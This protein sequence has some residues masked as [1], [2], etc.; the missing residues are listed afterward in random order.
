MSAAEW[1]VFALLIVAAI[2]AGAIALLYRELRRVE[3]E[4]T[5]VRIVSAGRLRLLHFVRASIRSIPMGGEQVLHVAHQESLAPLV[6]QVDTELAFS[7]FE[8]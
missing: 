4:L 2:L 8:G 7:E 5:R 1:T 6:G 3:V